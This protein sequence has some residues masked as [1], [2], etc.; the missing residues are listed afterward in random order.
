MKSALEQEDVQGI[1][2][3]IIDG[4]KP[5]LPVK[6]D[7]GIEDTL[8]D[9]PGLCKYLNVTP[10]W[11]HERTH[12]KEIPYYKLSNKHLRF[13]KKDIEIVVDLKSG[14]T[15]SRVWTCDLTKEYVHI[16]AEYET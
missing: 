16:N 13:R 10:K 5:L 4:L 15:A 9:V 1:V 3:A 12:L 11:I 14:K 2:S 8:L 7:A 6:K